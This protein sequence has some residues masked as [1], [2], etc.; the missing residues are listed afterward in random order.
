MAWSESVSPQALCLQLRKTFHLS[1]SNLSVLFFFPLTFFLPP[2]LFNLC[3]G[4]DLCNSFPDVCFSKCMLFYNTRC[5]WKLTLHK[6]SRL[7][8]SNAILPSILEY[9]FKS[10]WHSYSGLRTGSLATYS[11]LIFRNVWGAQTVWTAAFIT[12]SSASSINVDKCFPQAISFR[13][14][15]HN[16]GRVK[17]QSFERE[18]LKHTGEPIPFQGYFKEPW[19]I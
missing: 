6:K 14:S 11:W 9:C 1:N 19:H 18:R 8:K 17:N 13:H 4:T 15:T 12:D 16:K 2:S 5:N 7:Q 10:S 3:L